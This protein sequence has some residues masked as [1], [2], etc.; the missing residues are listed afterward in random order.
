MEDVRFRLPVE[1]PCRFVAVC[2]LVKVR[3]NMI[4][5]SRFQG[6]V[7]EALVV[8]GVIKGVPL[9]ADFLPAASEGGAC[10][11]RYHVT[12]CDLLAPGRGRTGRI[13]NPS[14]QVTDGESVLRLQAAAACRCE[15][16][17]G[18]DPCSC[19]T[20]TTTPPIEPRG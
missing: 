14:Y 2:Q 4:I 3:R 9:P 16:P 15:F 5:A 1:P 17:P 20:T 7:N 19:L 13:E 18:V 6:L 10:L 11:L 8:E 12:A